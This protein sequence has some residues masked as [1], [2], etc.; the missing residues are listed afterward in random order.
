MNVEIRTVAVQFLLREYLFQMFYIDPL[1]CRIKDTH[2]ET[3]DPARTQKNIP[4]ACY[5]V[6]FCTEDISTLAI[7]VL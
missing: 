7:Q 4:N 3:G 2:P 1:Q 6:G 5:Q